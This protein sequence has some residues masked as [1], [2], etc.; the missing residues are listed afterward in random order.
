MVYRCSS[1]GDYNAVVASCGEY[2]VGTSVSLTEG[3]CVDANNVNTTYA[4]ANTNAPLMEDEWIHCTIVY[5]PVANATTPTL[6]SKVYLNGVLSAAINSDVKISTGSPEKWKGIYLG[7]RYYW[8]AEGGEVVEHIDKF[9][10]VEFKTVRLYDRALTQQEVAKNYIADDYYMHRDEM[11]YYDSARNLKLRNASA[12]DNNGN[13]KVSDS[14][15]PRVYVWFDSV[16]IKNRFVQITESTVRNDE[17]LEEI[18][19]NIRYESAP[20]SVN[21]IVRFDTRQWNLAGT[22]KSQ[23]NR[24]FIKVQGT[25][26]LT[27]NH[28][29][30]DISFGTWADSNKEVLFSPKWGTPGK[31]WLPENTFTL[32]ADLIDSSH[33]NN[34]GTAKAITAISE[35]AGL[36]NAIPPMI[37]GNNLNNRDIK[38]A[39]DGFPCLLYVYD[40]NDY[41][42]VDQPGTPTLYGV[43]MFDLGRTSYNNM[44]MQNLQVNEM[45]VAQGA[46]GCVATDY[47]LKLNETD[48]TQLYHRENTLVYEGSA[49]STEGGSINFQTTDASVIAR[50]WEQQYPIGDV[51]GAIDTFQKAFVN[52]YNWD[53]G[54]R[55]EFLSGLVWHKQAC[56]TYLI[57]G[58]VFGMVDNL[59]KNMQVKTWDGKQWFPMFYDLD[60][61]LGLDNTGGIYY[62]SNVDLDKYGENQDAHQLIARTETEDATY[63]LSY[64][65]G[66]GKDKGL[67]NTK[68]SKLWNAVRDL[69]MW[70][71]NPVTSGSGFDPE[72]FRYMYNHLR[73]DKKLLTYDKLYEFYSSIMDEIGITFYNI[74]AETKYLDF[75][76]R[77]DE[78]SGVE[79]TG[80]N[81]IRMM[82]GT[83]ELLTKRWLRD[84]LIYLD[85]L[86]EVYVGTPH[87]NVTLQT[88]NTWGSGSYTVGVKTKCPVFVR[89]TQ[90][91]NDVNASKIALSD[92]FYVTNY[93]LNQQNVTNR[94]FTYNNADLITDLR[95]INSTQLMD[96][97]ISTA[98]SLLNLNISNSTSLNKLTLDGLNSLRYLD[99]SYC[100]FAG[101][102]ASTSLNLSK[103]L[104][105]QEVNISYSGITSMSLP[106]GGTLKKINASNTKLSGI[107]V[108]AQ[109]MLEELDLSNCNDLSYFR[110]TKCDSLKKV[111]ITNSA[112]TE[113]EI[114]HCP[115]LEE[116]ILT[117]NT[118][119]SQVS[120]VGCENIKIIDLSDCTLSTF[121]TYTG[122]EDI[123]KTT[124]LDLS[125]CPNLEDLRLTNCSAQVIR[126]S[127]NCSSLKNIAADN[128][129]WVQTIIVSGE[130]MHFCTWSDGSDIYPA[131]DLERQK[132]LELITFQSNARVQAITNLTYAGKGNQ[133]FRY[134]S[135]LR[136][137]TGHITL[138]NSSNYMF[139]NMSNVF[140]L[141]GNYGNRPSYETAATLTL[142]LKI[143]IAEGTTKLNYTF[144]YNKG[145]SLYDICYVCALI[146]STVTECISTFHMTSSQSQEYAAESLPSDL[147]KGATG[148]TNT[149]A[150]FQSA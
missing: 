65:S 21:E 10:D 83:R 150:M 4:S 80:Y 90:D 136:R 113:I 116:I 45:D 20:G 1:N 50:E 114:T 55:D 76:T 145:I 95:G 12:F 43:Y 8:V 77:N 131:I 101:S 85:S 28:K 9:S 53:L 39:I 141:N 132:S 40:Q 94:Q 60:T 123:D 19:C 138:D 143:S 106:V 59:G 74:D 128:S 139:A 93:T 36:R 142:P 56:I 5:E 49:N 148:L 135:A 115:S 144:D 71:G 75:Y 130:L 62:G 118:R 84:R 111:T 98:A 24:P 70:Y 69:S 44:G 35:E 22:G 119:L 72:S 112:L 78:N 26:S 7:A 81:N 15:L 125:G 100:P 146:P 99:C 58:Y 34:V 126:L 16:D 147:L 67:Y 88:R 2:S 121:A 137:I 51:P 108:V 68:G 63:E 29:N 140:R 102:E 25:T 32:K 61:V 11:G 97:Q 52:V 18:A 133:A 13:F 3:F 122:D 120:F 124:S 79:V 41:F 42:N 6:F 27:Y 110:L 57:C 105:L 73:T 37:Q 46:I 96:M 87:G 107:E 31:Q 64:G 109:T 17:L 129:K 149:T 47:E 92:R 89:Q 48:K 104:S 91:S 117:G 86:F 54:G 82:H 103:S 14:K 134:C 33:S 38:F 66:L 23:I 127:A 30:Y